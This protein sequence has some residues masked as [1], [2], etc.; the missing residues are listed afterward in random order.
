M[1]LKVKILKLQAGKPVSILHERTADK[2]SVNIDDRIAISKG[3]KKMISVVDIAKGIL[4]KDEIAVSEEVV[5]ALRL[6]EDDLVEINIAP[7]P[8]SIYLIHKKLKCTPLNQLE[9]E[10]IISD[11]VKNALTEPEIA[12]FVSAI[13]KCGMSIKEIEYLIR[14]I[15]GSGNVIKLRGKVADKH[16][17]GGIAGNRTTPIV[18]SICAAA[19]LKM[20]KTSSRAITSAAGTADAI[21]CLASVDFSIKEIKRIIKK[22]NAC[23]VW[24]G[25]LGLAPAD[26]KIIQIEKLMN[27]DPEPQ[28]LASILSKK[29]SVDSKYVLIDIPYGKSAKVSKVQAVKLQDKFEKLGKSF[30][31]YLKCIL[32]DG[33]QPIGNG[34]GPALEMK[35]VL[36]V[37]RQESARPF[38]LE[39]KSLLL[40]GTLLEMTG[41]SEKGKGVVLAENL[42]KSGKAFKKFRKIIK[43]QRGSVSDSRLQLGGF[44]KNVFPPK[45]GKIVEIDNRKINLIARILGSPTD[46][47]AGIYLHKH[48]RERVSKREILLTL[49][50]ES[51]EKLAEAIKFYK[52]INPIK[53]K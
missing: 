43:S 8:E 48:C 21:E 7:H 10:K 46:K 1:R 37:L 23:M 24:G 2:L 11:I 33:S 42:L 45:S 38:D 4:Q 52:K 53:L 31:I 5:K 50:A 35:D 29:L 20:P 18:I 13:Y 27:L 28:L 44:S 49:Y 12:Y 26:D 3:K 9:F 16:C 32:T 25:S 39:K 51:D 47:G 14:A 6:K 40:A 22:N 34:I 30:K 15:V 41:E 36:A 19:G 17:I